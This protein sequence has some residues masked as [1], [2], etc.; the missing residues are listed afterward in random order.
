MKRFWRNLQSRSAF[1]ANAALTAVTNLGIG[2]LGMVTGMLAA[3]LLGPHGR[4]ELAAI[5]TY[6]T[7]V[8]YFTLLGS[9]AALAYYSACDP[10][11]A[12]RYLGCAAIISLAG[13][14]PVVAVT[15]IAMPALLSAQSLAIVAAARWYLFIVPVLALHATLLFALRGRSEFV[16]WNA[17]QTAPPLAWLAILFLAWTH[18][19]N[20]P[21]K[22]AAAHLLAM[23]GLLIPTALVVRK[24]IPGTFRPDSRYFRPMLFYGLPCVASNFPKILNLRLDQMLM[25]G[26][27]SPENLG[28]YVAA[29]AWSGAINPL[30]SAIGAVLLPKVAAHEAEA[31]R[32]RSFCRGSRLAALFALLLTPLLLV[33]TPWGVVLLFGRNFRAAIPAALI[34]VPAGAIAAL[35]TV[36]EDGLRGLGIP[37]A[38]LYAQLAGMLT[39]LI[40]LYLLLRPMGIVGASI[41][42]LAGYS[43]IML[44]LLL[45]TRW[46]TGRSPAELLLPRTAELR[47]GVRE[48]AILARWMVP[49][50]S[51]V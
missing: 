41:A 12:G 13:C 34:L 46:L 43:T 16:P 27:L 45:E 40:S 15:Y 10:E 44:A 47:A 6:P 31:D 50:I 38:P 23:T 33:V 21:E 48:L 1:G 2:G 32:L 3:R 8:G 5:Q 7:M 22:L 19:I 42:S 24:Y 36:I 25:A 30:M 14:L 11:R 9:G 29:V 17:L 26:L 18:G 28:L 39:T 35:N 51:R 4:G 37:A 20:D 49:A